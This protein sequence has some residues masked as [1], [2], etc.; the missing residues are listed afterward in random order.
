MTTSNGAAVY[1]GTRDIPTE[2]LVPFPGNAKH[3]DVHAIRASID[4]NGQY[5][6]LVVRETDDDRLAVLAGNHTLQAL[7]LAGHPTARCE[8]I[9]CSDD[10]ARRINLADNRTADLGDYDRDALAELLSYLDGDYDGTGYT[11]DDVQALIAPPL[12][13][14][15]LADLATPGDDDW[16]LLRIRVP[17][18]VRDDF[19][20]LT[21]DTGSD[22][23]STRFQHLVRLAQG[24]GQANQ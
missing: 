20:A 21:R 22:D 16:P 4:R 23:D 11:D 13:A 8:V 24:A 1:V 7:I 19:H 9:H 14:D 12:T 15:E 3:G 10:T 6:S 2:Q 18:H 5:R 17:P